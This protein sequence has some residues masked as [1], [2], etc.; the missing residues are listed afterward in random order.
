LNDTGTNSIHYVTQDIATVN[1]TIYTASFYVKKADDTWCF[2]TLGGSQFGLNAWNNFN[3]DTGLFGNN[4]GVGSWGA[5][6]L[7]NGYWLITVTAT[8]T[9]TSTTTTLFIM[10]TNN[11]NSPAQNPSYIG[12]GRKFCDVAAI[13]FEAGS[14]ATSYI[15]TTTATVIRNAET[16]YVDLWNNSLLNKDNFTL[17]VEG[18]L[19][20]GSGNLKSVAL[21]DTIGTA[22]TNDIGFY[23]GI[24]PYHN[25]GGVSTVISNH[26]PNNTYYRFIIQY[27]NGVLKF[28]RNG[29]QTWTTQSKAVFD[30]RYLVVH[31]GVSTYTVDKIALFNR[32]LTD[33]ECVTLTT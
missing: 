33:A 4:G 17:F 1:G 24:N 22:G 19:Y 11:T 6:Q 31:N 27:N 9:A 23:G 10:G 13:Q 7:I 5:K 2:F 25:T 30:Y 14:T 15:P 8:A 32:T 29:V 21:S 16:S 18:Y 28:F 20:D 12:T 3:F 26:L